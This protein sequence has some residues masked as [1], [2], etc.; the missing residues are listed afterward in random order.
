[1]DFVGEWTTWP[2]WEGP[3][4]TRGRSEAGVAGTEGQG[5]VVLRPETEPS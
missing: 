2:L 5:V 3:P 1:M 4:K